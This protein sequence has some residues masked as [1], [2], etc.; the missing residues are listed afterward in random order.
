MN[1]NK[2]KINLSKDKNLSS[3]DII[4][5]L[6]NTIVKADQRVTA[7]R[8]ELDSIGSQERYVENEFAENTKSVESQ[9]AFANSS[10]SVDSTTRQKIQELREKRE[11][12][13]NQQASE[14]SQQEVQEHCVKE[15]QENIEKI[16][17]MMIRDDSNSL[18]KK[19][20]HYWDKYWAEPLPGYSDPFY[21]LSGLFLLPA[22]LPISLILLG[23]WFI[24]NSKRRVIVSSIQQEIENGKRQQQVNNNRLRELSEQESWIEREIKELV[25]PPIRAEKQRKLTDLAQRREEA[26]AKFAEDMRVIGQTRNKLT[27]NILLVQPFLD[28][29]E[30]KHLNTFGKI[31]EVLVTGIAHIDFPAIG[32]LKTEQESY[33]ILHEF[34]FS[35]PMIFSE[36]ED[37]DEHE[38]EGISGFSPLHRLLLRLLFAM[39][40]GMVKITA[41]DP[42]E[43][44]H[45]LAPFLSLTEVEE[46]VPLKKFLTVSDEIEAELKK[47]H[48]YVN[49][50]M[51]KRF[52]DK[53]SDWKSYNEEN[54]ND[55]MPFHLL[56]V[57]GFPD[58]CTDRSIL[59]LKRLL[60]F[61]P[62]CGIVP[63]VTLDHAKIDALYKDHP[64]KEVSTFLAE[65]GLRLSELYLQERWHETSPSVTALSEEESVKPKRN[66]RIK[67]T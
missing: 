12:I 2:D 23:F 3:S 19:M 7:L 67:Y 11:R 15:K 8:F 52:H 55:I 40:V 56:F 60:E 31:P 36:E 25:E 65:Q 44:G 48:D 42:L 10:P 43:M 38:D 6:D 34:P 61:G 41:I 49:D 4:Q 5:R 22:F 32:L 24:R 59:Y 16:K 33:P 37:A 57:F 18:G 14:K 21:S 54:P 62:R 39:P 53:V 45:S 64:A 28:S 17:C 9:I 26:I 46:L 20:R 47:H 35:E 1:L 29:L 66:P 27:E 58:Q 63:I 50:L 30:K 51:Q 13:Q